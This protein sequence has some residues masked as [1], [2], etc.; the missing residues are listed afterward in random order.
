MRNFYS[1]YSAYFKER[2]DTTRVQ[3][4]IREDFEEI[5]ASPNPFIFLGYDQD[6]DV[7][8]C[9]NYHIVK[10]RL[11]EK[12]SVS[13]YSRQFFQDEVSFGDFLRK[14]L[15]NGDEPILFKRKNLIEFFTQIETFFPPDEK[16]DD[17][18]TSLP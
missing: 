6:N 3:L 4:P 9:W 13:F 18:K 15:K 8:V 1:L 14:R 5:K 16:K 11:N 7:L 10:M 12:K 17:N 2:P